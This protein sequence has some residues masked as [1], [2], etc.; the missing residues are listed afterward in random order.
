MLYENIPQK[1]MVYNKPISINV[2]KWIF[3]VGLY[4]I[5]EISAAKWGDDSITIEPLT[6]NNLKD[7]FNNG[8]FVFIA[9]HG[10]YT[11]GSIALSNDQKDDLL[12]EEIMKEGGVGKN[13]QLVYIAGCRAGSQENQ[14]RES[15]APANVILFNRITWEPEHAYWLW[16]EGPKAI[17]NLK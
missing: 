11:E 3:Q 10:G 9:T 16:F 2:P 6:R 14:W 8:R 5:A 1:I 13:L 17:S 4:P 12:P 7:A 15:L